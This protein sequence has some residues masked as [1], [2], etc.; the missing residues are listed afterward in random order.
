V[1]RRFLE[2]GAEVTVAARNQAQIEALRAG[3]PPPLQARL[4][5]AVGDLTREADVAEVMGAAARAGRLD[6]LVNGVGGFAPGSLAETDEA[7]W[8]HMLAQNLKTVYLCCRAALAPMIAG[9]GGRIINV[10]SRSVVPPAG[11]FIAYTVAKTGVIAL[12]QALAQELRSHRVAVNVVLPGTMDTAA[13]RRAMPDADFATWVSPDTVA[14]AI[15]FVA[16]EA[17]AHLTGAVVPV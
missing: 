5:G 1:T 15:A 4:Y 17:A 3:V 10:G 9:G 7:T 2:A 6:V 11:G 16:S 13:N 14:Q 12:S 8:N